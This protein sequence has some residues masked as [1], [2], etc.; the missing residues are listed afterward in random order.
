M[1][2]RIEIVHLPPQ[3]D[4]QAVTQALQIL[5]NARWRGLLRLLEQREQERGRTEAGA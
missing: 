1:R 3:L 2:S 4:D 5:E